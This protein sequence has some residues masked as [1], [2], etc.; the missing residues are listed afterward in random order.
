MLQLSRSQ[1]I[2]RLYTTIQGAPVVGP[3]LQRLVRRL[4]PAEML[5]WFHI[6][7]GLGKGLWVQL[8]PRFE[9]DYAHGAYEGFVERELSL[10]LKPGSVFYDVGAHIGI[11]SLL[12]AR[13]VG[14]AGTVFAFEPDCGNVER[15]KRNASRNQLDQIHVVPC[16]AWCVSGRMCFERASR[17]SSHNQ[18][19][20]RTESGMGGANTIEVDT[21]A[22]DDFAASH[23]SPAL[24]KIDV[25]GAEAAV[26]RGSERIFAL[27][28][29]V[30]ICEIHH[31]AAEREVTQW[32]LGRGYTF[33]WLKDPAHFPRHV[34]A[35]WHG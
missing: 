2:R 22:L 3:A 6:S 26:L 14:T 5:A 11:L 4:V 8:D 15:I 27:T 31:E 23:D 17:H 28:K 24:I 32:L 16:A 35:R 25:E 20:L 12:A 29:P 33:E 18:G 34:V 7:A 30:L 9:I 13:L 1:R 21:I 10:H 19:T